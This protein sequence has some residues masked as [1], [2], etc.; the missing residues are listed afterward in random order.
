M[1]KLQD[2][3]RAIS[4][5]EAKVAESFS[6]NPTE[7]SLFNFVFVNKY[8]PDADPRDALDIS[9]AHYRKSASTLFTKLL[10]HLPPE[11]EFG[12]TRWLSKKKQHKILE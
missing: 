3:I 1:S 9:D 8:S 7:R 5:E 6:L 10:Q 12:W 4:E 2:L 11:E